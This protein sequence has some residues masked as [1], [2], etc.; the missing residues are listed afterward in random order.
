MTL[1]QWSMRKAIINGTNLLALFNRFIFHHRSTQHNT[2]TIDT[3]LLLCRFTTNVVDSEEE[4]SLKLI[5]PLGFHSYNE[6]GDVILDDLL[7][8]GAADNR[9]PP[10]KRG[11][12]DPVP[13]PIPASK[14]NLSFESA[15]G[16][17]FS[18]SGN[19][20]HQVG[21]KPE[22]STVYRPYYNSRG[23]RQ[24]AFSDDLSPLSTTAA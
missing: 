11:D 22:D 16:T 23:N 9:I 21:P 12:K 8:T 14:H 2:M 6:N 24:Q 20:K 19:Q 17:K 1:H 5:V 7:F 15:D 3:Q 4:R 18:E 13:H 10:W